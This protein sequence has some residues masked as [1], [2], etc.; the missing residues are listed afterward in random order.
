M[1]T[2][3]AFARVQVGILVA[4]AAATPLSGQSSAN[5]SAY[6]PASVAQAWADAVVLHGATRT[7]ETAE[8]KYAVETTYAGEHRPLETQR[9]YLL[10][11]WAKALQQSPISEMF[12]HEIRI[13]SGAEVYWLPL[14]NALLEPFA[15]EMQAGDRVRLHIMYIGAIGSERVFIIN[16]FQELAH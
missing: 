2:L 5:W 7:I 11:Q 4:V 16:R 3:D 13:R 15:A 6:R 12:S 10:E 1:A 9:R 14:Q 8:V